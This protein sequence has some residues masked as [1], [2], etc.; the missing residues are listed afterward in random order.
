MFWRDPAGNWSSN[1]KGAGIGALKKHLSD[2]LERVTALEEQFQNANGAADYFQLLQSLAPLHR[3]TRNLHATLQHARELVPADRDLIVARDAGGDMERSLELLHSDARNGLEYTV[4]IETEQQ[5]QRSYEM[6]VCAHRL[7]LLAAIFFPIATISTI[8]DM[9]LPHG[10]ETWQAPWLFWV[11]LAGGFASGLL[12]SLL[13]AR[14]PKW[15]ISALARVPGSLN[16]APSSTLLN[17]MSA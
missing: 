10:L 2:T 11:L 16:N 9:R 4:A 17:R 13:V 3:T 8:F 14:K 1:G 12:L 7:N 6:T 5:S 15:N